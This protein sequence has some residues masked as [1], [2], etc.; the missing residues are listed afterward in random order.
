MDTSEHASPQQHPL[1]EIAT[2][3]HQV[4]ALTQTLSQT[5][6]GLLH[7]GPNNATARQPSLNLNKPPEFDGKDKHQCSSFLSHVRLYIHGNPTL[8]HDE[9]SKVIFAAS[10]LRGSAFAWFEPHLNREH[11]PV[12]TNFELFAA[13][14]MHNLGDPDRERTMTRQ[15]QNLYQTTSTAAYTTTFFSISSLLAWNDDA[16]RAQFYR[17]LKPDVKDALALANVDPATVQ[18]LAKLATRLDNR[19]HERR[20]EQKPGI[21][22]NQ[23]PSYPVR[24][25]FQAPGHT[26]S[27]PT[28][29]EVDAAKSKGY[30]PL[31]PEEKKHRRDN[32]LCLYCGKPGHLVSQCPNKGKPRNANAASEDP[33]QSVSVALINHEESENA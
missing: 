20:M 12:C 22:T 19:I 9:A 30:K 15:L 17:G 27:T 23:Q 14:L 29:M 13:E 3:R 21:R 25:G 26:S 2:L 11:D 1:E 28:Q 18:D 4:A 10:Y 7:Q 24:S 6:S 5:L 8:F 31:T 16:L 33:S 32:N